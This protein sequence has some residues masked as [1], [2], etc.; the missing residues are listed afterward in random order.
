[1]K[2]KKWLR[3][4]ALMLF[5]ILACLIPVPLVLH[6]RKEAQFNDDHQIELSLTKDDK[7]ENEKSDIDYQM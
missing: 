3:R 2:Y 5:I 7:D 4:S 1:M 6:K